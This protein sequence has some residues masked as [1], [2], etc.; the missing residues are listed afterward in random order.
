MQCD[1]RSREQSYK[2]ELLA[3]GLV[4]VYPAHGT[5]DPLGLLGIRLHEFFLP[6]DDCPQQQMDH[7]D[8][9]GSGRTRRG[10]FVFRPIRRLE[11][12]LGFLRLFFGKDSEPL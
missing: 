9:S 5:A 6:P 7:M 2:V 11:P 8:S 3:G 12:P 4:D 1:V 10:G